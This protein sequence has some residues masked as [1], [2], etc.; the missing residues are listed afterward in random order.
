MLRRALLA[1][2]AMA[3]L[4]CAAPPV[5]NEGRV[6]AGA[7]KPAIPAIVGGDVVTEGLQIVERVAQLGAFWQLCVYAIASATCEQ[8]ANG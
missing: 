6:R 7:H 3:P 1:A 8:H 4:T 5:G 2:A